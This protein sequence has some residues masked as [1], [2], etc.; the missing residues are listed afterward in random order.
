MQLGTTVT[1]SLKQ[2]LDAIEK[3]SNI[4]NQLK[5]KQV[6]LLLMTSN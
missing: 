2:A 3:L 6:T 5:F 4:R 1:E